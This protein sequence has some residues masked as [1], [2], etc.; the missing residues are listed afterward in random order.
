[1]KILL[2]LALISLLTA[3]REEVAGWDSLTAEER[4]YIRSRARLECMSSSVSNFDQ[5]MDSSEPNF[6]SLVRGDT[7]EIKHK[8]KIDSTETSLESSFLSV[9]NKTTSPNVLYLLWTNNDTSPAAIKFIKITDTTNEEMTKDLKWKKCGDKDNF[10]VSDA[11]SYLTVTLPVE[12]TNVSSSGAKDTIERKFQ[13]IYS[14]LAYLGNFAETKTKKVLNSS[15]TVT[16]TVIDTY[17]IARTT[18]AELETA[19]TNTKYDNAK[20]CVADF[21]APVDPNTENE[22]KFPYNDDENLACIDDDA[23]TIDAD[24]DGNVDFSPSIDLLLL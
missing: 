19:Y 10:T 17:T 9:W 2:I 22:Y 20:Y 24:G 12:D 5:F 16:S 11:S 14:N 1:M 3:C 15:G 8:R 7:W 23:A 18:D 21:S 4:L 13:F 6:T